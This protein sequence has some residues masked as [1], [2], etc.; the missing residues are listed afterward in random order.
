MI[1]SVRTLLSVGTTSSKTTIIGFDTSRGYFSVT[2]DGEKVRPEKGEFLRFESFT[3][4]EAEEIKRM[5]LCM[6]QM[7]HAETSMVV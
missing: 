4:D 7:A 5:A 3:S 2:T 6:H 1:E